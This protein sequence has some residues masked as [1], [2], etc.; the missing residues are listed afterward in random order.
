M[1]T[2]PGNVYTLLQEQGLRIKNG[3]NGSRNGIKNK[4]KKKDNFCTSMTG[5]GSALP[6]Y[7]GQAASGTVTRD[8]ATVHHARHC[9]P[10]GESLALNGR[11]HC[12]DHGCSLSQG[13]SSCEQGSRGPSG[14]GPG[15]Q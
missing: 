9:Q 7:W 4:N 14:W 11:L 10:A 8:L 5:T 6:G 13:G 15:C 2:G 3:G 12:D 1:G